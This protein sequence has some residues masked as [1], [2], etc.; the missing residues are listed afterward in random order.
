M[1]DFDNCDQDM[2]DL[3][4]WQDEWDWDDDGVSDYSMWMDEDACVMWTCWDFS[5]GWKK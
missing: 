3:S 4:C 5:S 1:L 2:K